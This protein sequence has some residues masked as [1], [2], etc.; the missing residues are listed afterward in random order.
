MKAY[1]NGIRLLCFLCLAAFLLHLADCVLR[2]KSPHGVD[3]MRY[4]YA[5]PRNKIDVLF[6]GT[7]HMHC[8]VDTQI[9][10]EEY[11][12]AAYLCT[13]AE[14]PL[15]NSYYA[16]KE[17]LKTQKPRLVVLDVFGPARFLDDYQQQWL[18]ENLGG[19]K[20]SF[21]KW[22][23]VKASTPEN[24]LEF[25]LG[26]PRYHDRYGKLTQEDFSGFFWNA[27]EMARWKGYTPLTGC[28][29]LT[30]PDMGHVTAS[31]PITE[32][33]QRYLDK[34]VELT[35][36]EGIGLALLSAPYL[37][38]E[39]DQEAYNF[40]KGLA[41]EEDLLFLDCNTTEAY[42]QMGLDFSSDYADHAHLNEGG[43]AKFTAFL[44]DWIKTNY[45]VPDRR[46]EKGYGSWENQ[47][48][49]QAVPG[50]V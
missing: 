20:R 32:K 7:S 1:K 10:W 19:M 15:W 8:N 13:G 30:E 37:L 16:L 35:R 25:F 48:R 31:R 21:N 4:L 12:I 18:D 50:A 3:Q 17:A 29:S 26:Y 36:E 46:Q 23:A 38:E 44:G 34:I 6:L 42:R 39:E 33:S 2:V 45:E 27:G 14:Q 40:L 11:G 22:E 47:F 24:R 49:R 9:L 43:S 41:R 5:Q 28:A